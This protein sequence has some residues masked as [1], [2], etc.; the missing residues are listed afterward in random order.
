MNPLA[1]AVAGFSVYAVAAQVNLTR[2]RLFFPEKRDFF[3]EGQ[4][5]FA[6]GGPARGFGNVLTPIV[7]F[8]RRIGLTEEG[9]DPIRAGG[10]VTGRAGPYRIGALNIQTRGVGNDPLFPAT[11]FSVLRVR[12]DVLRRSDIGVIATYRNSSLTEEASSNAAFGFDGNFAFYQ[13][14][15]INSYYASPAPRWVR[16][17]PPG[18]ITRATWASSTTRRTATALSRAPLRW[19]GFLTGGR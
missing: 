7:F 14:L 11:N 12:R 3:L 1:L 15:R 4:T 6:F 2:F 19:N 5:I 13:N 8:S 10:R 18:M 9:I 17:E 16:G